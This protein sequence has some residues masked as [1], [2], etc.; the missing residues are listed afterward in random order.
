MV[1]HNIQSQKDYDTALS[2]PGVMVVD[3]F[4]T[5]CGPCKVIAPTVVTFSDRYADARFYK[6]DVD[7]LPD[8]AQALE[9]R[10]MPTFIIFKDGKKAGSVVGASPDAL[11]KAVKEAVA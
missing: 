11:E 3:A 10:A 9:V 6:V 7:E 5:W 2:Q 1:V 8:V 4:A